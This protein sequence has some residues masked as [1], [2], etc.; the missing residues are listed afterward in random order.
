MPS[1]EDLHEAADSLRRIIELT[2]PDG[3]PYDDR[4]RDHLEL[5]ADVLGAGAEADEKR[6][7]S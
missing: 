5:A 7:D 6:G 3:S 4:L 1:P 2:E